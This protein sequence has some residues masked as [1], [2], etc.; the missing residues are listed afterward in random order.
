MYPHI[1]GHFRNLNWRYLPYMVQYL[2]S[3]IL[4]F[5]LIITHSNLC[6]CQLRRPRLFPSFFWEKHRPSEPFLPAF[7]QWFGAPPIQLVEMDGTWFTCFSIPGNPVISGLENLMIRLDPRNQT[8]SA[9][10]SRSYLAGGFKHGFYFPFHICWTCQC[11]MN[12]NLYL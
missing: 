8:R 10:Q 5:P 6:L 2:H 4:K 1:N 3:R 7:K 11:N 9:S 12:P